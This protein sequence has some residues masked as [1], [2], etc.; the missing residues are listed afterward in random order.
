MAKSCPECEAPVHGTACSNPACSWRAPTPKMPAA[1]TP[2][3]R[4]TACTWMAGA[5]RCRYPGTIISRGRAYCRFHNGIVDMGR[6]AVIVRE[7]QDYQPETADEVHAA[8]VERIRREADAMGYGRQRDESAAQY[9]SR[10]ARAMDTTVRNAGLR[11]ANWAEKIIARH[12]RG[13]TVPRYALASAREV[14]EKR[15]TGNAE[16]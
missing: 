15:G 14:L 1:D 9:A 7:S 2:P 16:R 3:P 11:G 5:L 6:A 4:D 10:L 13:E 8:Q 12:E